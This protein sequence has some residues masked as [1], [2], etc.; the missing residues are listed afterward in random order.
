M[1]GFY[2]FAGGGVLAIIPWIVFM[3]QL[4]ENGSLQPALIANGILL[5]I[6]GLIYVSRRTTGLLGSANGWL[7]AFSA[8]AVLALGAAAF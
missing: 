3:Y 4:S 7:L 8:L 6:T 1:S 5:V 2:R